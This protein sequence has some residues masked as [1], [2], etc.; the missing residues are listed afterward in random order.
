MTKVE[1]ELIPDPDIKIFFEKGI[2]AGVACISNRYSKAD[3]KYL[4]FYDPKQ[5]SK[6]IIFSDAN[7]LYGCDVNKYTNNN[8]K[9]C[10]LEADLQYPKELRELN[11]D[12]HLA[13][14]KIDIKREML[15]NY[16]SKI[17]ELY[18]ISIGNVKKLLPNFFDKE[19]YVIHYENLK[20]YLM[21]GLKLKKYIAY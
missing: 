18:N 10:V 8:S 14:D 6:H 9:V 16:Q 12:Y 17:A 2:R 11:N 5:E 1:L 15:S 3:N 13:P 4:K 21:L 19:R 7:N 20:V